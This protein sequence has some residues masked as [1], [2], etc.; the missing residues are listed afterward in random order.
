MQAKRKAY[1]SDL[2]TAQWRR[3]KG[4]LPSAKPGGRHRE[5]DLR[6]VVDAIL[7]RIK[8]GC[9]WQDLPHDFP[10]HQTVYEYFR[11]W[12]LDGTWQRVHDVLAAKLRLRLG[13][14]KLPSAGIVDSQSVKTAEKRGPATVTTPPRR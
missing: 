6:E 12:S 9:T 5:V 3:I 4:L 11:T 13:R 14:R 7:Y 10:P 8:H 2:G 1:S